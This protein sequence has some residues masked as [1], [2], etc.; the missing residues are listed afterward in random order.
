MI[1]VKNRVSVL[2]HSLNKKKKEVSKISEVKKKRKE[3]LL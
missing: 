1:L 3:N 2:N